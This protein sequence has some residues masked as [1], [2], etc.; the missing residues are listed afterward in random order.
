MLYIN[1]FY[2]LKINI[3]HISECPYDIRYIL[4][5]IRRRLG[6]GGVELHNYIQNEDCSY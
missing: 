6:G 4:V 2:P 3:F 5:L 1:V